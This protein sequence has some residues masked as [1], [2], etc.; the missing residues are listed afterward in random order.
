MSQIDNGLL[1]LLGI[2]HDDN[3]AD[4]VYLA[5]KVMKMRLWHS[6]DGKKTWDKSCMQMGYSFLIVS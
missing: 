4:I 3:F 6:A 5:N 2:T 1:V